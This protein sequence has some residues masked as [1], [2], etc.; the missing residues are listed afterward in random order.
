MQF[1]PPDKFW[2]A[3][4]REELAQE[5]ARLKSWLLALLLAA[6][7]GW[8]FLVL[9]VWQVRSVGGGLVK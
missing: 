1:E 5:N 6:A 8:L 7:L 2:I 4:D 3:P 9:V